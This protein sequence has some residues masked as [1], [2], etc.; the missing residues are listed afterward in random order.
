MEL[1]QQGVPLGVTVAAH[2]DIMGSVV[3]GYRLKGQT[4]VFERHHSQILRDGGVTVFCDH[5][6]GDSRYGYMPPLV[7]APILCSAPC[8]SLITPN[9][10]P[11]SPIHG[12]S[13]LSVGDC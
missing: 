5:L 11:T 7:S 12:S 1:S 8:G 10:K 9:W 4:S 2:T 13:D 6:G 3:D